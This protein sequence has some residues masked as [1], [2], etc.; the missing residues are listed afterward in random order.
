MAK[1]LQAAPS[2]SVIREELNE[3]VLRDLLGPAG[4]DSE[5]VTENNVRDRYLVGMLA[6]KG[7]SC[8]PGEFDPLE[9]DSQHGTEDGQTDPTA[10]PARTMFPSSFGMTFCID[11][12]RPR[13][14][15]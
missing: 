11:G 8:E 3:A 7:R 9:N 14:S 2:A 15:R 12:E 6:P 13:P 10:L 4:G 5:E 1:Q